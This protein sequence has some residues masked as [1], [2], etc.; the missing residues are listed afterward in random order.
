MNKS[1]FDG[2]LL[3]WLGNFIIA[4]IITIFSLG[5]AYPWAVV[6]MKRWEVN[7]TVINGE[8]LVFTGT[9]M[10]LL[11]NWIK[12]WFFILI[13]LGIYGFWVHIKIKQWETKHTI[14]SND[15]DRR[16]SHATE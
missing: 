8:R 5:I 13:T 12:W 2:G 9:G 1:Y 10:Q 4:L 3:G 16:L 7:H 15:L 14:F 11:G 6:R